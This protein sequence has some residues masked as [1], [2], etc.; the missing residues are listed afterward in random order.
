MSDSKPTISTRPLPSLMAELGGAEQQ[1]LSGNRERGADLES[2]VRIFLE[3]LQ[4]SSSLLT[5]TVPA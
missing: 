1:V 4:D 3:L 2:A 5:L